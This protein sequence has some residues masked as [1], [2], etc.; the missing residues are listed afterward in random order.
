MAITKGCSEKQGAGSEER[1]EKPVKLVVVLKGKERVRD[2]VSSGNLF[3]LP[4]HTLKPLLLDMQRG[5]SRIHVYC[6]NILGW[7]G[8]VERPVLSTGYKVYS[9]RSRGSVGISGT[10]RET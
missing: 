10:G 8:Q 3:D 1:F 9:Y 5:V 4:V 2:S 6:V 7:H